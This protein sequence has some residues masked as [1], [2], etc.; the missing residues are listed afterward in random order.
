MGVTYPAPPKTTRT[1]QVSTWH[2]TLHSGPT[3]VPR[4]GVYRAQE[5]SSVLPCS[6]QSDQSNHQ[7]RGR[8][9]GLL[10]RRCPERTHTVIHAHIT[11]LALNYCASLRKLHALFQLK[12][13]TTHRPSISSNKETKIRTNDLQ[14]MRC[15]HTQGHVYTHPKGLKS[16]HLQ[17]H[18]DTQTYNMNW[19]PGHPV[20]SGHSALPKAPS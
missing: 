4:E 16:M 12:L 8:G 5:P 1:C 15:V 7:A 19:E 14:P 3:M 9:W 20:C 2:G 13:I 11:Y 6:P 10:M 18:T 17:T